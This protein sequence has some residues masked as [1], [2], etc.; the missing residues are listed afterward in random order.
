[1]RFLKGLVSFVFGLLVIIGLLL[2]TGIVLG[3][4]GLLPWPFGC[5][6]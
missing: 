5:A 4:C 3:V 1:M 6:V 2:A